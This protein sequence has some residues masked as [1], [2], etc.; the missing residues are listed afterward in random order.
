MNWPR[1]WWSREAFAHP[2]TVDARLDTD[3][4]HRQLLLGHLQAEHGDG[5]AWRVARGGDGELQAERGFPHAGPGGDDDQ[6]GGLEAVQ[7]VIQAVKPGRNPNRLVVLGV[8]HVVDGA[9]HQ[10]LHPGEGRRG[11]GVGDP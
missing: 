10:G 11:L 9:V 4:A 2:R 6:I 5:E 8:L 7:E 1:S 3:H